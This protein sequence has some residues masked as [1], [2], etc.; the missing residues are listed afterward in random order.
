MRYRAPS[1]HDGDRKRVAGADLKQCWI[2]M[3][4]DVFTVEASLR[5]EK[6]VVALPAAD[7]LTVTTKFGQ[8]VQQPYGSKADRGERG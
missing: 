2:L 6:F 8:H 1:G 5:H 7:G 4:F 3:D